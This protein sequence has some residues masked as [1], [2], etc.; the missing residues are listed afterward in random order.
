MFSL[1]SASGAVAL[2][3]IV[4]SLFSYGPGYSMRVLFV[5]MCRIRKRTKT[6][7]CFVNPVLVWQT[8]KPENC[9]NFLISMDVIHLK[10]FYTIKWFVIA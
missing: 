10:L 5:G 4:G 1:L 9:L 7:K 6:H 2:Q 8:L 3:K